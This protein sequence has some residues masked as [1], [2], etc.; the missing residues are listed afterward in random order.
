MEEIYTISD[1]ITVLRDGANAGPPA[2]T[3]DLTQPELVRRMIGRDLGAMCTAGRNGRR[4]PQCPP[5][6][7]AASRSSR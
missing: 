2:R 1:R 3:E 5:V 6:R 4:L 7:V